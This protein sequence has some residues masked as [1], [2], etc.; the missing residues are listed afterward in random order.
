MTVTTAMRRFVL[1]A[2]PVALFMAGCS[3][4]EPPPPCPSV[5]TPSPLESFTQFEPAGGRD[6]TQVK[7]SGKFSGFQS[8]CEYD[9]TG[10]DVDLAI[11]MIVERGPADRDRQ[12]DL[13]YF[14]A[15]ENGPGNLTAKHVFDVGIPFEGNS[16]R[17]ARV[18]ELQLRIPLPADLSFSK[19]RV[20]VGFQLTQE[21]VDYNRS[22]KP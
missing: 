9:D 3:S 11:Q 10:V 20:L 16:R 22:Q 1:A 7:F 19:V 6:L 21:Q 17:L 5:G 4:S 15:V 2:V 8:T 13:Q 18:E 12:A 14:V